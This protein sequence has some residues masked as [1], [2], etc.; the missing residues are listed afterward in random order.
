MTAAHP[1]NV[2]QLPFLLVAEE[3]DFGNS[4]LMVIKITRSSRLWKTPLPLSVIL[5]KP[6]AN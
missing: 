4:S 3:N 6:S 2:K 5:K 1:D